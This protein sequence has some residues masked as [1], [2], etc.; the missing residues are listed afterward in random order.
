MARMIADPWFRCQALS[1]AAVHT[2]DR[3]ARDRAISD[4]FAAANEL[5]EPNRVV[6]VSAWPVKALALTGDDKQ[7]EREVTRLL[8][9]ISREASPVRRADALR[10]LFGAVSVSTVAIAR[11]VVNEFAG[12]CVAPLASGKRN[13]K[14]ESHLEECLPAIAQIDRELAAGLLLELSPARSERTAR[15]IE[16]KQHIPIATLLWWPNF[17]A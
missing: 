1:I 11:R 17:D 9:L 8:G 5:N 4:A 16:V 2:S 14:G 15:A 13:G 10:Y 12:A 3:R 7:V 6:T